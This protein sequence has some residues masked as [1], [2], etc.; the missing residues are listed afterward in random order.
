MHKL[1]NGA[2]N[3]R[4]I[5]RFQATFK[6]SSCYID[7]CLKVRAGSKAVLLRLRQR[8]IKK[9]KRH[10]DAHLVT[11]SCAICGEHITG[12]ADLGTMTA[13]KKVLFIGLKSNLI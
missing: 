2:R 13:N 9:L 7:A 11:Q 3:R 1:T 8:G 5:G 10:R 6:L 12:L 4:K